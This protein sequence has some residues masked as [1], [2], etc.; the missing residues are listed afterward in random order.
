[1]TTPAARDSAQRKVEAVWRMEAARLIAGLA[2]VT[3]D[4]GEAEEMA[5]EALVAALE[6]W[7]AKGVPPNPAGWLMTTA[8]NRAMDGHRRRSTAQRK[9]EVIGRDAALRHDAAGEQLIDS[10]DDHIEDDVLRLIFTACHP[11]LS[12]DARVA[13]TLRCLGGLTTEEIAH[14]FLIPTATAAQRIVRAKRALAER[15]IAFELPAPAEMSDRLAAVLE[16]VYLL[17]NEGYAASAGEDLMRPTLCDQALRLGRTLAGLVPEE[18]EV[19]GLLAL[20]EIQASR[21]AARTTPDGTPILLAD[22]DRNRWDR[23]LIRRGIDVPHPG[24]VVGAADR[25]LHPPGRHRRMSRPG[26]NRGGHRLGQDRRPV[27]RPAR[28]VA[29]ARGGGEPA[30]AVGMS[31]GPAQGLAIA[32]EIEASGALNNYPHLHLVRGGLRKAVREEEARAAFGLAE[33]LTHNAQERA[34][35]ASRAGETCR[36]A[37]LVTGGT[38]PRRTPPEKAKLPSRWS[39]RDDSPHWGAK[40][41]GPKIFSTSVWPSQPGRA[42][43]APS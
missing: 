24:R 38:L 7:P 36:R 40:S 6:Q 29:L 33:E 32:D 27:R 9:H 15:G 14:A 11:V 42:R 25:A 43:R 16:V 5:Q 17:F 30:V 3:G 35:F 4:I 20:M 12:L 37:R 34:M 26:G 21:Q 41:S 23:L 22:Q 28:V 13:L 39:S 18:P 31:D 8:K 10:L 2:R 19:H 1:M